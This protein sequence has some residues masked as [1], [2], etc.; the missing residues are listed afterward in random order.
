MYLFLK[1]RDRSD[2]LRALLDIIGDFARVHM[3]FCKSHQNMVDLVNH[4]VL[5]YTEIINS[6]RL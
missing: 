5:F 1:F 4:A 2:L 3:R 6:I